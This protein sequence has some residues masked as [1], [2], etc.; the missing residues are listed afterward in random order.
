MESVESGLLSYSGDTDDVTNSFEVR[1]GKYVDLDLHNA[2][3]GLQALRK[4]H[5]KGVERHQLGVVLVSINISV[6]DRVE[7]IRQGRCDHGAKSELPF[8]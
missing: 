6:G 8:F 4:I 7:V 5:A 2:V 1:L 3:V